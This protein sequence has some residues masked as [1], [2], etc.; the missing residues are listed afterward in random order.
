MS[1]L[2]PEL[3]RDG[4]SAD[5][6]FA[7]GERLFQRVDR[8]DVAKLG[9]RPSSLQIRFPTQSVNREKYS[10][11]EWV[12]LPDWLH[13]GVIAFKVE[14]VPPSLTPEGGIPLEFRVEH[15]PEEENYAHSEIRTYRGDVYDEFLTVKSKTLKKVFRQ[16]LAEQCQIIRVPGNAAY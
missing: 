12:L 16:R 1:I 9:A 11:P 13:M 5:P 3:K 14:D 6:N 10:K 2:P 15:V 7:P 8:D 4:R